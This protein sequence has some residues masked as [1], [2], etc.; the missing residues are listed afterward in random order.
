MT[1]FRARTLLPLTALIGSGLVLSGGGSAANLDELR[2][3]VS[4][5]SERYDT[6]NNAS[7]ELTRFD[8]PQGDVVSADGAYMML[9]DGN[10]YYV[11]VRQS[12]D[13]DDS[14]EAKVRE[15]ILKHGNDYV[16]RYAD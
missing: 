9:I 16:G 2:V 5:G 6:L 15:I 14:Y 13:W 4:L 1:R 8:G 3:L 10:T 7:R 11:S 12:G